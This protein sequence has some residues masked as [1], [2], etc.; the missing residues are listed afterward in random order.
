MAKDRAW[1]PEYLQKQYEAMRW[2]CSMGLTPDEIRIMRWGQVDE[3]DRAI[4]IV[5][6][7]TVLQYDRVT[8]YIKRNEYDKT[9][10]I[11][12]KKT[13][14][15]WFFL[16]SKIPCPWMFTREEPKSWR[17]EESRDS[18]FTP[19]EI[20]H[21]LDNPL[22][23]FGKPD[24]SALTIPDYFGILELS[25]LNITKMKTKELEKKAILIG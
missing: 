15:E 24:V 8:Q 6:P 3:L 13:P 9:F 14:C 1:R 10:K 5:K 23:F 16:K 22:N 7:V 25:N 11:S 19:G 4:N 17:K 20:K 2:L 12:L 21:I 18:L